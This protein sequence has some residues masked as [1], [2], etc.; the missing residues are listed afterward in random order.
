M[1][2]NAAEHSNLTPSQIISLSPAQRMAAV[3]SG[4]IKSNSGGRPFSRKAPLGKI[5]EFR[6][7][8]VTDV[9]I[10]TGIQA[11]TLTEYL[12]DRKAITPKHRA[13]LADL[14]QVNETDL[15]TNTIRPLVNPPIDREYLDEGESG[16]EDQGEG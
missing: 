7:Y 1:T 10:A 15:M 6:G 9:Y 3:R 16:Y 8:N 5:M 4:A 13:L 12:A 14:L 2:D 11:R